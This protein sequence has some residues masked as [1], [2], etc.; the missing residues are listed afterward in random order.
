LTN[1]AF[2]IGKMFAS[3]AILVPRIPSHHHKPTDLEKFFGRI[4]C[5]DPA[6]QMG[7]RPTSSQAALRRACARFRRAGRAPVRARGVATFRRLPPAR[8]LAVRF[9]RK[10][11][12]GF[13]LR[14][15][16]VFFAMCFSLS[17]SLSLHACPVSNRYY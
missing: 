3:N 1:I 5:S 7:R 16:F 15:L 4:A 8:L 14:L 11:R 10:A 9:T 12:A 17:F 2:C 13:A 6:E